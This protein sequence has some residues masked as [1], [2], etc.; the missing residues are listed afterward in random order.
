MHLLKSLRLIAD[1]T[2]LRLLLLLEREELSVADIQDILGMGQSRISAQLSQLKAVGLLADRRMGKNTLYRL[3]DD[4]ADSPARERLLALASEASAE[5][6]EIADDTAALM[7]LLQKRRDKTRAYFNALAGKFGRHACPGRSWKGLAEMLLHFVPRLV[8]VDLGAGEGTLSQ[9]LAQR[10][11]RVIAVDLSENMVA[12]GQRLAAEHG[13]GN[14]EFR[15]GDMENP[16]VEAGTVDVA[17]FSQAL[18]HAA[19]PATA[20]RAAWQILKTG[21]K[22]IVLDLLKHQYE[23]AREL[24]ADTWLG[25]SEV[26]LYRMLEGAGFQNVTVSLV[27]R[28]EE[29]PHFQTILAIGEKQAP[30]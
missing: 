25:F 4:K 20:L 22:L 14:L 9:M 6:P 18:H 26:E 2:R 23:E 11:E 28:E 5:I 15:L 16:P 17:I 13:L 1:A 30:A 7:L 27:N 21:G 3:D 29:P 19:H 10:A 8:I 12:H 24:Y